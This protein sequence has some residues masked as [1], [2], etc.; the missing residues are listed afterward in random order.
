MKIRRYSKQKI[1]DHLSRK[2]IT[3]LIGARQV[4]KTTLLKE[5]AE[6][7]RR[8]GRQVIFLTLDVE[9]DFAHFQSQEHLLQKIRLAAGDQKAF[10]FID[11]IQRKTNAGRFLK[12][13]YDMDLPHKFIVSGSGSL[14]LKEKIHESLAG[15]KRIFELYPV[16][17][18]EFFDYR[19]DYQYADRLTEWAR[20]ESGKAEQFL[21]EY[22]NYGGYPQVILTPKSA[23]KT[24]ILQEI[25][26]SYLEKDM[27]FLLD[28]EKPAA[29]TLLIRLLANQIGNP[30]NYSTLSRQ[31]GLSMPTLKK[32]LWYAEKTFVIETLTPF[33]RNPTKELIKAPEVYFND[34]GFRNFSLRKLGYMMDFS[35]LGHLFE[36][37]IFQLLR[38]NFV[39][40][41]Q[42]LKYWRTKD[43]AEVDFVLER[44]LQPLP[45]EVKCRKMNRPEISRSFRRFIREYAPEEAWIVNLELQA[46]INI[47][48]TKV[49]F[50]P[51]YD[52]A[53]K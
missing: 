50:V 25:F 20:I 53:L 9:T 51:W 17:V 1:K 52:L 48:D 31:T 13:L 16:S 23:E 45:V 37:F 42:P 32:Y 43:K 38:Q 33:F 27:K 29:F 7:L 2:E 8:D 11:E 3:L 39:A 21:L 40:P 28:I 26:Q 35:K 6:E 36:N 41:N 12:G 34:L 44:G 22:L 4:G 10:I 24:L 15:R 30:I 19:T 47:A 18:K 46:E 5:I 14:E 49:R